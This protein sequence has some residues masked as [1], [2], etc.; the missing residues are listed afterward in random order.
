M[1]TAAAA[2]AARK[3]A[4]CDFHLWFSQVPIRAIL[5]YI[6]RRG[7]HW[8][9][10]KRTRRRRLAALTRSCLEHQPIKP[11]NAQPRIAQ[12]HFWPARPTMPQDHGLKQKKTAAIFGG[13]GILFRG[14]G[15][16][17]SVRRSEP[18]PTCQAHTVRC[19]YVC[20]LTV[21]L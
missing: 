20:S 21:T 9:G 6:A 5:P 18:V 13:K 17:L 1:I 12:Q 7:G 10:R 19:M 15:V 14:Y 16:R 11:I 3:K 8:V 4:V 2:A